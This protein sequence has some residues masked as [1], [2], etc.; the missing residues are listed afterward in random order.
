MIGGNL[1]NVQ[2]IYVFIVSVPQSLVFS[3]FSH[4][5]ELSVLEGKEDIRDFV[6][7]FR[8]GSNELLRYVGLIPD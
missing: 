2:Y 1:L 5:W 8:R 6:L 4:N 7:S 3:G